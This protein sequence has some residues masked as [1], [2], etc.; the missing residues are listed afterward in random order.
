MPFLLVVPARSMER[1]ECFLDLPDLSWALSM[2]EREMK[3]RS[4]FISVSVWNANYKMWRPQNENERD[5]EREKGRGREADSYI[6]RFGVEG[7]RSTKLIEM[8][9]ALSTRGGSHN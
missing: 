4:I 7:K 2:P 6:E 1:A 9:R 8:S 5:K 3:A